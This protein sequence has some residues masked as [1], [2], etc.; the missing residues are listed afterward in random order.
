MHQIWNLAL[1]LADEKYFSLSGTI[2]PL[3][4]GMLCIVVIISQYVQFSHYAI[5]PLNSY[6]AVC[7]F[8]L[9]NTAEVGEL[10]SEEE[11]WLKSDFALY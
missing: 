11:P 2:K 9:H 5:H 4:K 8:Y 7:Q 1:K 6:S 10:C 3:L